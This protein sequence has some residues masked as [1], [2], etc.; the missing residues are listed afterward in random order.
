MLT[1]KINYYQNYLF[2]KPFFL[3]DDNYTNEFSEIMD[4]II[5][6]S[7]L[8]ELKFLVFE[9]TSRQFGIWIESQDRTTVYAMFY[10]NVLN[11]INPIKNEIESINIYCP[12]HL[13]TVV[14]E[15]YDILSALMDIRNEIAWI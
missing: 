12:D 11:L 2:E 4:S 1:E 7:K 6:L 9:I 15:P 14:D 10:I 13:E 3:I 8:K 5:V